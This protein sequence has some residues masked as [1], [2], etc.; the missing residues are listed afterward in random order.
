MEPITTN[1]FL[2]SILETEAW[3]EVSKRESLSMTMLENY[4]DKL[5]WKEVC[6]N[7]NVLWTIEG[8]N[9]FVGKIDWEEFSRYCPDH[10]I[11]ESTLRKFSNRWDWKQLS[12]RDA[13]YNNW[14]LLEKFADKAYWSE[15]ITKWDI[16]KPLEFFARFRQYIPMGKLQD[17]RLWNAM[18]EARARNIINEAIGID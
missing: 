4:S 9:K 12:G 5:D 8:I 10:I 16:E 14:T 18:A 15:V 6:G 3:K 7:P 17:S 2:D 13:F 1:E 11:C